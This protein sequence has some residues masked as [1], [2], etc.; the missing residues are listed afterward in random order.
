MPKIIADG[1][2]IV[3]IKTDERTYVLIE[4]KTAYK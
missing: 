1:G 2:D 3:A 4:V